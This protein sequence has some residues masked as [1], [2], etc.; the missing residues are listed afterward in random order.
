V[1]TRDPKRLVGESTEC[2]EK[3]PKPRSMV[4][5]ITI[6]GID[7]QQLVL[8]ECNSSLSLGLAIRKEDGARDNEEEA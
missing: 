5:K 3:T 1:P 4:R 6:D 2:K 8:I 7:F